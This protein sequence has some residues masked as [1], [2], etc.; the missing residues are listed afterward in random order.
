[1]VLERLTGTGQTRTF[2]E[3]DMPDLPFDLDKPF[4]FDSSLVEQNVAATWAGINANWA[5]LE[6][7]L[8]RTLE[9]I[10]AFLSHEWTLAFFSEQY[11][12]D[13]YVT[14]ELL[15]LSAH[16]EYLCRKLDDALAAIK[17]AKDLRN[18]L[19]HGVWHRS[20]KGA[21]VVYPLRLKTEFALSDPFV[22]NPSLLCDLERKMQ[23]AFQHLGSLGA[24]VLA[25]RALLGMNAKRLRASQ[26]KP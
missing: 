1:M 26:S 4:V 11:S 22:L 8:Y 6:L 12:R 17:L 13:A 16:D 18:P 3:I 23:K 14:R 15:I 19:V 5:K 25:H 24:E 21:I 9:P 10:D 20:R 2:W 7:S